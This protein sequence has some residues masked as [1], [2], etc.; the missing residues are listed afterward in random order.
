M[1][2][3]LQDA[4]LDDGT[5]VNGFFNIAPTP[6]SD[7]AAV[8]S[9]DTLL[10]WSISTTSFSYPFD[11]TYTPKT[12]TAL[13]DDG[14]PNDRA[15]TVTFVSTQGFIFHDADGNPTCPC[16]EFKLWMAADAPQVVAPQT[17]ILQLGG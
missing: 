14:L 12:S 4:R 11:F 13:F 9:K 5:H 7:V 1:L 15:S 16:I 2:W 6:P 8:I 10:D 3:T 17:P